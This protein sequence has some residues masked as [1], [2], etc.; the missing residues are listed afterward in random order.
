MVFQSVYN[1]P[2]DYW[3]NSKA[4]LQAGDIIHSLA[5]DSEVVLSI[6]TKEQI[7]SQQ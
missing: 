6:N 7:M 1:I 5:Y 3:V 2:T 4:I